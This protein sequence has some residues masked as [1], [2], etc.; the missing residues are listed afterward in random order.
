VGSCG[1]L[2]GRR[3]IAA[4]LLLLAVT[5]TA[6]TGRVEAGAGRILVAYRSGTSLVV[7]SPGGGAAMPFASDHGGLQMSAPSLSPDGRRALW[8]A[9][10]GGDTFGPVSQKIYLGAVDGS[11]P[12]VIAASGTS[13]IM[14]VHFAGNDS[15]V[16]VKDVG[17]RRAA[18]FFSAHPSSGFREVRS[19]IGLVGGNADLSPDSQ[20]VAFNASWQ[21]I[22][23]APTG[24]SARPRVVLRSRDRSV[25]MDLLAWS[26]DNRL[27]YASSCSAGRVTTTTCVY[28]ASARGRDRR[29]IATFSV[30]VSWFSSFAAGADGHTVAFSGCSTALHGC[31]VWVVTSPSA[32]PVRIARIQDTSWGVATATQH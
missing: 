28:S 31:G 2:N 25:R 27:I 6:S 10:G 15:V 20:S 14:S 21:T 17:G 4:G 18:V 23:V 3:V 22:V 13:A 32:R 11:P 26:R 7:K 1:R 16:M 12:R 24:P 8:V 30:D 19:S 29:R 5:A 9:I